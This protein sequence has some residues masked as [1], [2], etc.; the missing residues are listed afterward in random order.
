MRKSLV[1]AAAGMLALSLLPGCADRTHMSENYGRTLRRAFSN[2]VVDPRPHA[3]APEGLDPEEATIVLRTYRRSL[4][5][6]KEAPRTPV[7]VVPGAPAPGA[8]P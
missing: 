6:T 4:S 2:Q 3:K 8:Q 7:I 1:L 5:P